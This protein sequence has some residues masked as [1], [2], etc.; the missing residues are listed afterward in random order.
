MD[1]PVKAL[2][3]EKAK[4]LQA[5]LAQ[6]VEALQRAPQKALRAID[7]LPDLERHQMLV[8]W[9]ATDAA[10]PQD[11]SQTQLSDG[12]A[13][14]FVVR[15]ESST[16][17]RGIVRIAVLDDPK[18]RG[19][20]KPFDAVNWNHRV[21]QVFGESCGVGF[22]QGVNA[23]AFVLGGVPSGISTDS[24]LINFAGGTDRLGQGDVVRRHITGER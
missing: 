9:N 2:N 6:L 11:T 12:R 5:A 24:I 18:A 7:V 20:G 16:I 22:R 3:T 4:A 21:L 19:E 10:Y 23:P 14:P 8:Q 17:N 13:V 1:A 15:V